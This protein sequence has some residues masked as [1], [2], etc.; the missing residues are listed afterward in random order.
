M[1]AGLRAAGPERAHDPAKSVSPVARPEGFTVV[2][3]ALNEDFFGGST[4]TN[5]DVILLH[6]TIITSYIRPLVTAEQ[7][8]THK[9]DAKWAIDGTGSASK[10]SFCLYKP[11]RS[12]P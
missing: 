5:V 8:K 9:S 3:D 6:C 2:R 11:A 7:N 1:A 10:I 12:P 4:D